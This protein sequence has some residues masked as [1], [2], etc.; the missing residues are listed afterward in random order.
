ME[1]FNELMI[2]VLSYFTWTFSDYNMDAEMKYFLG[3]GYVA[4]IGYTVFQ[5]ILAIIVTEVVLKL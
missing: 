2:L 5:N 4:V 3:W 1:K